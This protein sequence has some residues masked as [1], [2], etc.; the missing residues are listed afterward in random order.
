MILLIDIGNTSIVVGGTQQGKLFFRDR[1]P[2]HGEDLRCALS[3]LLDK[4]IAAPERITGAA[5]TSVVPEAT[6][7]I[8]KAL[9]ENG[10]SDPFVIN[11]RT[12]TGLT[13]KVDRPETVGP[14]MIVGAAA[15]VREYGAPLILIDMGTATTFSYIDPAFNYQGHIILPGIQVSL[16]ALLEKTAQL[17][18]VELEVPPH[19]IGKNTADAMRSGMLFGS[20]A[21]V[22]GILDR[23]MD[24]YALT[25]E[26]VTIVATGGLSSIV[27]PLCSHRILVE[28]DLLL[29]GLY[30][31]YTRQRKAA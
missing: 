12:E 28:E 7:K 31:L 13:L 15:A 16:N 24:S 14:D 8:L 23:I 9:E 11:C 4:N 17:P 25:Q 18:P 10:I 6:E 2:T 5:L 26:N 29:E 1:I 3:A 19:I 22:D 21:M 27:I 30:A 20:A